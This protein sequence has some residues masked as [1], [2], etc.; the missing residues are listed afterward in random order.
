MNKKTFWQIAAVG[1]IVIAVIAGISAI[2]DR[3]RGAENTE[4]REAA[5]AA[6]EH[7]SLTVEGLYENR[8]VSIDAGDTVLEVLS[9]LDNQD[10]QLNLQTTEYSGL[11]TL[12]EGLGDMTNGTDDKYWQYMVNGEM[13]HVGADAFELA[14]GDVVRWE[15]K[16]SEF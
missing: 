4:N 10:P 9:A 1:V 12:V 2:A 8:E 15:F 7:I 13:P 14:D 3:D 16:E 6:E 5:E 11:G